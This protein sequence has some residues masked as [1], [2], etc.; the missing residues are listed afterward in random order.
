MLDIVQ[1]L[2]DSFQQ[3]RPFFLC[4]V[5]LFSLL[6]GSFLN[7]VIYRLPIMMARGWTQ[8]CQEFLAGEPPCL[9]AS[10]DKTD[11]FNLSVPRSRCP[12]CGHLINVFENIPILSYLWLRG[13]CA[14]CHVHISW[15]YPSIELLTMLLSLV[16]AWHFGVTW[17]MLAALVLTWS[18]IC[19]SLI[20]YDKMLLPDEITL[21]LLWLGLLLNYFTVF[22]DL[23]SA[24]L[25]AMFGYLS[26]WGMYH[27]FRIVTKKHGM[28]Y[29]DFKLLAVFG[30]WLGWQPVLLIIILSSFVGAAIGILLIVLSDHSKNK[31]IPYGPYL[32]I[33]GWIS[34]L[35]GNDIIHAYLN[36]L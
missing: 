13:Q 30:A 1:H 32:A 24:V 4:I 18:L 10:T 8:E 22:V 23:E 11:V 33:A 35:Y 29:G 14:G 19:L 20:D 36:G 16:V 12:A 2:L 15:R 25:G 9:D 6:I 5:A 28:G 17:Q 27:L 3:S 31:P 7:V 34:L 26:L 21:P